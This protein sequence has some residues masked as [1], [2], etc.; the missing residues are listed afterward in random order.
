MELIDLQGTT[1]RILQT[2]ETISVDGDLNDNSFDVWNRLPG[3]LHH[4][5]TANGAIH[6]AR[7]VEVSAVVTSLGVN[8]VICLAVLLIYEC[9]HRTFPSVYRNIRL[10]DIVLS[11][12]MLPLSWAPGILRVSWLQ[13]RNSAG[14]D[15][16]F[17]LRYIRLCFQVT[18]VTGLWGIVILWPVYATGGND[19]HGWYHLSM[20][21]L[22]YGSWRLW[23][24]TVFMCFLVSLWSPC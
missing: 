9:A 4:N 10:S 17:F 2:G 3:M 8:A 24:P 20:A 5:S 16:Y 1:S 19:A 11:K 22:K 12:S 21:N 7:D 15:G 6:G 14:M 13:V 23:F 18:A